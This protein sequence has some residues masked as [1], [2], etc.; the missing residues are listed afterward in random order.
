MLRVSVYIELIIQAPFI[1]QAT[2]PGSFGIDAVLAR[3]RDDQ[4]RPCIPGTHITGKLRQAWEEFASALE[5]S[6]DDSLKPPD[7]PAWLGQGTDTGS[8][9]PSAK[10]LN[11]S[12]FVL[13][14]D[15]RGGE[16]Y[17]I[18]IDEER[19][20]VAKGA[21]QTIESP[22]KPGEKLHF[23]GTARFLAADREEAN[24]LL[25]YL[26]LGLKWIPQFGAERSVG[27][28][29][30]LDAHL[31]SPRVEPFAA[32]AE[33][34]SIEPAP[35]AW[36]L[37]IKPLTPFCFAKRRVSPNLFESDVVIPG[38]ALK[39][40]LAN[41]LQRAGT[42]FETLRARL[43]ALRIGHAFP[44]ADPAIRPV[45]P[46]QSLVKVKHGEDIKRYD[47]ALYPGPVLIHNEAP[48][49]AIDWKDH[50]DV[51]AEFGWPEWQTELRVRT[52]IDPE[53]LRSADQQLFAY[54]MI[55]P[56]NNHWLAHLDLS[57]IQEEE[58]RQAVLAQLK[59][60]LQ[61]PVDGLGK[62][63]ARA[64]AS[65]EP[66]GAFKPKQHSPDLTPLNNELWLI[67]LQTPALL[68]D[69]EQLGETGGRD[70][71]HAAYAE[72]W[73]KL[74]ENR[75]KL[76]RYFARQT[77]AGGRYLYHRFQAPNPY[78]PYL[79]TEAGS[80]F[81]LEQ[82]AGELSDIQTLL[83]NWLQQ[84]LPLPAWAAQRYARNGES[85]D[86]WRNCP[87]IRQN[88]Y[89]EIAVNLPAHTD[90]QPKPEDIKS[91]P[92]LSELIRKEDS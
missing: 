29:R 1:S 53:E 51:N 41:L 49:F 32:S 50:S 36:T 31:K 89:G 81:V 92:W 90:W 72:A 87:Y 91:V 38:G 30:L 88:G 67:T 28:G 7:I 48:E 55:L 9:Q 62:T 65:L 16:R 85:G 64:Q 66:A 5:G 56:G 63:K 39:G 17:R 68:C 34:Q 76:V 8:W 77:L 73:A 59:A 57:A 83:E 27:F 82:V 70:A 86:H 11:L 45:V 40:A 61:A 75:L 20:A 33:A 69:P 13:D 42:G 6:N 84:G 80:V 23:Q 71:L 35:T 26:E 4:A 3:T 22:F 44:S 21:Y 58:Q 15:A 52:A 12:D 18:R 25:R 60:L 37:R 10:R 54:E 14:R 19:G 74:S 78:R 46:P 43:E 24:R 2:S 79:L 47:V